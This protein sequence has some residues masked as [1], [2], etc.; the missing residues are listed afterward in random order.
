MAT[1]VLGYSHSS[2]HNSLLAATK[3][4]P[5]SDKISSGTPRPFCWEHFKTESTSKPPATSKCTALEAKHVNKHRYFFCRGLPHPWFI[6]NGPP[7]STTVFVKARSDVV[8][9]LGGNG[10]IICCV[11]LAFLRV[12]M[13]HS[14]LHLE[15]SSHAETIQNLVENK[16]KVWFVPEQWFP[17][18]WWYLTIK[19]VTQ[20]LWGRMI[21]YLTSYGRNSA[22]V[23]RPSG[24]ITPS[25]SN[26]GLN[27]SILLLV[28]NCLWFTNDRYSSSNAF[29]CV[30]LIS[31]SD[32][33]SVLISIRVNLLSFLQLLMNLNTQPQFELI[34]SNLRTY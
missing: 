8:S 2:L 9:L 6:I 10:A 3:F 18:L 17:N 24:L 13:A 16:D 22:Y 32:I 1:L 20:F 4:V 34:S 21:G 5:L 27:P 12:H 29:H 28:G 33:S 19:F 7:K 26:L 31:A 30:C 14:L 11:V 25:L 23:N 15:I